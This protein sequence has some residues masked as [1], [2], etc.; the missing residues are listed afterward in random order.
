MVHT[1]AYSREEGATAPLSPQEVEK[2]W[3]GPSLH[4][5]YIYTD[6]THTQSHAIIIY[7]AAT[8]FTIYPDT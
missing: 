5:L 6:Y 1:H 4:I 3:H 8:L 7:D 2:V